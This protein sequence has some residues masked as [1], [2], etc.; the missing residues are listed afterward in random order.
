MPPVLNS[1]EIVNKQTTQQIP[2]FPQRHHSKEIV[3]NQKSF[4]HFFFNG[5]SRRG[6]ERNSARKMRKKWNEIV[7]CGNGDSY[8]R[9]K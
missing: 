1:G 5:K 7:I 3:N 2:N 9:C 8:G 6:W 4:R